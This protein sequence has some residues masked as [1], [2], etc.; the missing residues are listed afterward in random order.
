MKQKLET[1]SLRQLP[2]SK[3]LQDMLSLDIESEQMLYD[4]DK[5]FR[6]LF[7]ISNDEEYKNVKNSFKE[8]L[9]MKNNVLKKSTKIGVGGPIYFTRK[10]WDWIS[11]VLENAWEAYSPWGCGEEPNMADADHV[12]WLGSYNWYNDIAEKE[13][14]GFRFPECDCRAGYGCQLTY[15]EIGGEMYKRDIGHIFD[16]DNEWIRSPCTRCHI[17]YGNVHHHPCDHERCPKCH[18]EFISCDHDIG[19]TYYKE[20]EVRHV[21][22]LYGQLGIDSK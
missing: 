18:E 13:K 3:W 4:D 9:D 19:A 20:S 6:Q 1:E 14:E 16:D 11:N 5:D 2:N 21:E 7:S 15:V 17:H 22:K 8:G 12:K 10:E